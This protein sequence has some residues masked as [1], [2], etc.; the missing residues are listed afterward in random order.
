MA[1]F[2]ECT[3]V[4]VAALKSGIA[5]LAARIKNIRDWL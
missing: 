2:Y 4:E 1:E 3:Q 5:E